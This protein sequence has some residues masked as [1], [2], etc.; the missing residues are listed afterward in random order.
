MKLKIQNK[1]L[2][3]RIRKGRIKYEIC[4]LKLG[5]VGE[6]DVGMEDL[7]TESL[8]SILPKKNSL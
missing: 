3:D 6:V 1:S 7:S 8:K 2:E 4:D 5:L